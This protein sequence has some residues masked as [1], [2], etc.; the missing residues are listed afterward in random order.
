VYAN[1]YNKNY[2]VEKEK[3]KKQLLHHH[4]NLFT[5][6]SCS[7]S[8]LLMNLESRPL[9]CDVWNRNGKLNTP[10]NPQA[11]IDKVDMYITHIHT[12]ILVPAKKMS[13]FFFLSHDF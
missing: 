1:D 6:K 4:E 2:F 13:S 10:L 9:T 7:E 12:Y 11:K 5:S 8:V 3:K